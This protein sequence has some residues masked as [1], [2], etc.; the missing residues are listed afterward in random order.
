M[1]MIRIPLDE[2]RELQTINNNAFL[3]SVTMNEE[4]QKIVNN[5]CMEHTE[6]KIKRNEFEHL[7]A[8]ATLKKLEERY[9]IMED[10]LKKIGE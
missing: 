7:E 10:K 1:E 4:Y 9:A 6:N 2:Y 5:L 3:L 8:M